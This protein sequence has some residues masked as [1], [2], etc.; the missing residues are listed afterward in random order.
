ML[1]KLPSFAMRRVMGTIT[2][3]STREPVAALTFDDGPAPEFTPRLLD[4]LE[5]HN[6]RATFFVIGRLAARHR[7][8]VE[9]MSLA[10]HSIGNHSWDHP[11]FPLIEGHKRREQM[12]A[13]EEAT[14]PY[15]QRLFRPPYG[16]QSLASRLDAFWLGYKVVGWSIASEDWLGFDAD[17]LAER[18]SSKIRPGSV[19]LFHDA[20][21]MVLEDRFADRQPTVEAVNILLKRLGGRF[22][23]VTVPE[24]L[25]RGCP[26][27]RNWYYREDENWLSKLKPVLAYE[28]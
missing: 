17:C 26:Q 22:R 7:K 8:L 20:L 14:G 11:S 10:G 4:I 25:K 2:H 28:A 6:A 3:V 15:G 12:R 24:L 5:R 9:R 16:H 23:F 21:Y 27:Q 1:R 18:V 13:W 19:V